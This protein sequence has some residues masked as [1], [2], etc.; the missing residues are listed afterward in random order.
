VSNLKGF[1]QETLQ[2]LGWEVR[3]NGYPNS[4]EILLSQ[5]LKV[6]KPDTVFDIGANVGQYAATLR[7]CGYF[8]KIVSFEAISAV[9]AKLATAA[10]SDPNWI[11]A[12][13]CALG[14]SS[15][16]AEIHTS[17]NS[18]SSSLLPMH[19]SH[20][21]A[22]P[23]SAYVAKEK[24]RLARLDELA[25]KLAMPLGRL[26]LKIDTQGYEEEVLMGAGAI[27]H[28]VCAMQLELSL[29]PL[30]QGAPSLQQMLA[31]CELL[32]FELHGLIPGFFERHSGKLLQ[33]D[34]LFLRAGKA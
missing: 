2:R 3:R 18:V 10:A 28:D 32:G 23:D 15:G 6:A 30:Y 22:E 1:V 11:V 7:K 26:L 5:F 17:A 4:E 16:E 27:L 12:P 33:M 21:R 29:T 20:L 25:P 31:L 24:V 14:R 19:E 9:H 8:G 13:C 34:G